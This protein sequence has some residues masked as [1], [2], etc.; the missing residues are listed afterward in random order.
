LN[1]PRKKRPSK[2]GRG[3]NRVLA[4]AGPVLTLSNLDAALVTAGV[5]KDVVAGMTE[6][7]RL[8]KEGDVADDFGQVEREIGL[9]C[10][11]AIRAIGA[12]CKVPYLP[13]GDSKFKV[14]DLYNKVVGSSPSSGVGD[15][16]RQMMP[17]AIRFAYTIRNKRGV[18]HLAAITPNHIDARVMLS[19]A[20]WI[21][22][23][24]ARVYLT[25]NPAEAQTFVDSIV[26]RQVPLV[27]HF[28]DEV[29]ILDSGLNADDRVLVLAYARDAAVPIAE[30]VEISGLPR[31]SAYR[32]VDKLSNEA[33]L[34]K[35]G[36]MVTLTSLGKTR[37][38]AL[39]RSRAKT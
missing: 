2:K 20:D 25:G 7:Y 12:L 17:Y 9:F 22:A 28:G 19:T 4:A 27:E 35:S 37:V 38:E 15:S 30:A 5:P 10:E 1:R 33:F 24:F 32:L 11:A 26:E 18:D 21:V 16:I 8:A 3:A 23:E 14:E 34:H 36:N 31:T 6:H 39:V 29:K 13:I